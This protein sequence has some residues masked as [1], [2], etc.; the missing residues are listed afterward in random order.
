MRAVLLWAICVLIIVSVVAALSGCSEDICEDGMRAASVPSKATE[1]GRE[2]VC[3][4]ADK[5]LPDGARW[6]P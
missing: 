4:P 1:S 3:L 2:L 5:P 6:L